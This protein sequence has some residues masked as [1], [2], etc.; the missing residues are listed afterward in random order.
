MNKYSLS[1]NQIKARDEAA[2]VRS[3]NRI[4]FIGAIILF[5]LY[6]TVSTM[7]YNDCINLGVC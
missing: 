6:V 1:Y 2:K 5:S 3:E 4:G 7:G